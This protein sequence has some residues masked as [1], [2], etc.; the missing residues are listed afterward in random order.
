MVERNTVNILIDVR[1][2]SRALI[3]ACWP[4]GKA[5]CYGHIDTCSTLVHVYAEF[6]LFNTR[7]NFLYYVLG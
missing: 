3:K 2:I 6:I 1:F 4:N 7:K 5:L